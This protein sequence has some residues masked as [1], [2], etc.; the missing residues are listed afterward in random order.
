[1]SLLIDL[2]DAVLADLE[3][4]DFGVVIEWERSYAEWDLELK[5]AETEKV[6]GDVVPLFSS[7]T[8]LE[9]RGSVLY[10][11]TLDIAIRRR[12][13]ASD[14]DEAG[15]LYKAE[16]D[17]LVGVLEA[18]HLHFVKSEPVSGVDWSPASDRRIQAWYVK[19]H[20]REWSQFTGI[21]R[22]PFDASQDL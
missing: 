9:T 3:D 12:F 20:L 4:Q 5:S 17:Q 11:L 16:I 22:L 10:E 19:K 1:M 14:V 21:V 15:R 13:A 6:R 2:A 8:E 7:G 18:V